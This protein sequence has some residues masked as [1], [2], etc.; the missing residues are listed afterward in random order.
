MSIS[1][2]ILAN[3]ILWWSCGA[4]LILSACDGDGGS[5]ETSSST[6]SNSTAAVIAP[7]ISTQLESVTVA[8]SDSATLTVVATGTSLSYPSAKAVKP[9]R[10]HVKDADWPCNRTAQLNRYPSSSLEMLKAL[11]S[12][13][14]RSTASWCFFVRDSFHVAFHLKLAIGN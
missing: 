1:P 2:S 13:L 7:G 4:A 9:W 5:E 12:A 6:S 3:R 10:S 8:S 11:P 14:N